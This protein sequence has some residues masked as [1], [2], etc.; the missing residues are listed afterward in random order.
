MGERAARPSD[1]EIG[2]QIRDVDTLR[3]EFL[4]SRGTIFPRQLYVLALH[5][6]ESPEV[7]SELISIGI[8]QVTI[9]ETADGTLASFTQYSRSIN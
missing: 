5:Q 9:I 6:A 7:L 8:K 4:A 1:P 2:L 3:S